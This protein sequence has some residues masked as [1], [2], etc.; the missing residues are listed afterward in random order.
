MAQQMRTHVRWVETGPVQNAA[1]DRTHSLA[2]G[3][4]ALRRSMAHKHASCRAGRSAIT[5]VVGKCQA[6]FIRQWESVVV[7][8]LANFQ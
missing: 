3:K 4:P 6:D 2:I 8:A 5:Q 1:D 7:S